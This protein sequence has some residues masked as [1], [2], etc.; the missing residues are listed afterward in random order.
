MELEIRNNLTN[1]TYNQ[2]TRKIEGKAICFNSDSVDMG[3]I[4]QIM[5]EACNRDFMN[6]QDIFV[7]FN[8][9]DDKVLG[10]NNRGVGNMQYEIRED[11]VYFTCDLLDN[12][13]TH[14]ALTYLNA[15]LIEG[16]SFGFLVDPDK[17]E[18]YRDLDG[19]IRRNIRGFK[20]IAEFSIVFSPAYSQTTCACRSLDDFL[21]KEEEENKKIQ[22]ELEEYKNKILSTF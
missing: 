16:C 11:G 14:D 15:G 10:R 2:E 18:W 12:T 9:E 6:T 3:F 5:P 7:Y 22:E 19:T 13:A 4:E 8:H 20:R 17:D 1:F 21:T